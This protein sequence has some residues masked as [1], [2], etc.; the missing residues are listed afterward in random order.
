MI[1]NSTT[2]FFFSSPPPNIV[3]L[4]VASLVSLAVGIWEDNS[5]NHP[6]DEPKVGW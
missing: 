4:T 6:V 1:N 5:E 2:H 3:M